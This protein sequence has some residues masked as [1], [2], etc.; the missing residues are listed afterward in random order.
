MPLAKGAGIFATTRSPNTIMQEM[1]AQL[2]FRAEGEA[3]PS[4]LQRD[5]TLL[6]LLDAL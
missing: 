3:Y 6:F 4:T 5:E 1:L 2:D